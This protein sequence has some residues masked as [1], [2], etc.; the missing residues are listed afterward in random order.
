MKNPTA[1]ETESKMNE[2]GGMKRA[3]NWPGTL[4]GFVIARVEGVGWG[5][6][7]IKV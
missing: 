2:H 5:L 4:G 7:K 3:Q 1:L 6:S